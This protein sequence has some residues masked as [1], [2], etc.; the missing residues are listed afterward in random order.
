MKSKKILLLAGSIFLSL[1]L[2]ELGIRILT[3]SLIYSPKKSQAYDEILGR[4]IDSSLPDIDEN[5]FR[6]PGVPGAADIVALGDSHTYGVNVTSEESWPGQ[7]AG[8]SGMTVYNMGVGGYGTLQYYYLF[9]SAAALKPKHII[10]ALYPANDL[11]DVCKLIAESDYWLRWAEERGYSVGVC[12]DS[13]RWLDRINRTL[14][15]LHLYWIA[16]SAV[17]RVS[18]SVNFGDAT[19]V[20]DGRNPTLI[21]DRTLNSHR[22]KM[23]L[24][25]ERISLGLAV[26][27]DLLC[28]MKKRADSEGIEFS[29]LLIPSKERVF[30]DYLEGHGYGLS[31][32]YREMVDNEDALT[33]EL[34]RFFSKTGIRYADARPYVQKELYGSGNVYSRTDDGH[35]LATGYRA[36][37][38]AAYEGIVG[39]APPR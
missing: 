27:E 19:E 1:I 23:D 11:N 8:I 31:A 30:F 5:G 17:K 25:R 34:S 32:D 38:Q 37:A 9:D 21:K 7:L 12:Y 36:Y 15:G 28:E 16:A 33:G 3:A 13:S 18:E 35:P 29:V 26:T 39:E 10:L 22:R 2:V 14:S 4:K 20:R 24:G 6:N